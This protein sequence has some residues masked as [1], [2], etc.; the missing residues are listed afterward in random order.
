MQ[1]DAIIWQAR[2]HLSMRGSV[3]MPS[4]NKEL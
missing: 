2:S 3:L 4:I 1:N